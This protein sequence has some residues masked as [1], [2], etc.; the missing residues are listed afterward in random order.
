[1]GYW[2]KVMLDFMLNIFSAIFQM[3]MHDPHEV[4]FAMPL[5]MASVI[6][7]IGGFIIVKALV[8]EQKAEQETVS[9]E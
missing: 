6:G 1:M 9:K 5:M 7:W 8:K 2:R 4:P 3:N